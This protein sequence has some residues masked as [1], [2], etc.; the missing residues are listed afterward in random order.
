[1][2]AAARHG[3]SGQFE[4][5][6]G[7]TVPAQEL[8]LDDL[9]PRARAGLT[10][11]GL[12]T[13]DISNYLDLIEDRVK[14]GRTGSR[15]LV[16]SLANMKGQGTASERLSALS[17][18]TISRQMDGTPGHAWD[19]ARLEEAGG[20]KWH[21]L[22]VEQYMTTDLFTVREEDSIDLVANLM[23]WQKVRH[24][25]VEDAKHHLRGLVSYRDLLRVLARGD[26][27]SDGSPPPVT[28]I[29]KENPI[30][31]TPETET[32][33]AIELMRDKSIGCLPVVKDGR[34]VGVVTERDFMVITRELL[35]QRLQE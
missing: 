22:H 11:A 26:H 4:W 32:I 28:S 31:V 2:I 17:R 27:T 14:S 6:G 29:M 23:D 10:G 34:L 16:Q 15:W 18:A 1:F 25:P 8:L 12:D 21:Y 3:L 24:V 9:L 13:T 33:A 5:I 19:M 7:R 35:C 20:W 30:T